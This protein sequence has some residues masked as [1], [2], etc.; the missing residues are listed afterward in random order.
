MLSLALAVA[1]ADPLPSFEFSGL[2]ASEPI[3][4]D[5]PELTRCV[6]PPSKR[7][8][9][10]TRPSFA[11]IAIRYSNVVTHDGQLYA[12]FIGADAAD[13][14]KAVEALKLKYGKPASTTL[15]PTTPG[16]IQFQRSATWRFA[17]GFLNI[18]MTDGER[19]FLMGFGS[20]RKAA[21]KVDF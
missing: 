10:L 18:Q 15:I 19:Q 13:Y 9:N 4:A 5:T 11:D 20:N 14:S 7:S 6:G 2:R 1:L 3:A 16:G 8:C 17:D 21:P 12:L